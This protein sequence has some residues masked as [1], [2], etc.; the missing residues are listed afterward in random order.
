MVVFRNWFRDVGAIN[1]L[2][3]DPNDFLRAST[4]QYLLEV[5]IES[6][7]DAYF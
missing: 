3:Y 6:F 7:F 2:V 1:C 4:V 5:Y